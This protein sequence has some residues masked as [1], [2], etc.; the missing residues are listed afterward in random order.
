MWAPTMRP[1]TT[2]RSVGEAAAHIPGSVCDSR[3][4]IPWRSI[5]G[6]R[7]VIMHAYLGIDDNLIWLM[8]SRSVPELV[9][10]LRVLLQE[11]EG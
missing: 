3:R 2:S 11:V 6:A 8:V 9:P 5:V 7:N 1:C 10:Q 4:N